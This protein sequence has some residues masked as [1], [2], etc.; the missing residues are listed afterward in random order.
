MK[1]KGSWVAVA[2]TLFAGFGVACTET[3]TCTWI[4]CGD[5]A[6]LQITD[7]QV[8]IPA[9]GA[10]LRLNID[11]EEVHCTVPDDVGGNIIA[12]QPNVLIQFTPIVNIIETTTDAE[13]M[14]VSQPTGFYRLR[15]DITGTPKRIEVTIVPAGGTAKSAVFS[16]AYHTSR[17]NGPDCPP[18]CRNSEDSWD[19]AKS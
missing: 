6:V 14:L 17:P 18:V 2:V 7:G 9:A 13:M 3:G 8:A 10:D 11:G 5:G 19:L 4:G 16:P 1:I 12:C 15:V